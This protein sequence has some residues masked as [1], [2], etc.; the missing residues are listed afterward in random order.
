MPRLTD[1]NRDAIL[2]DYHT[3]ANIVNENIAS[4]HNVSLGTINNI[5][6]EVIPCNEHLVEAASIDNTSI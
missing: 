1:K 6:K 5:T 3:K 4:K 2:A